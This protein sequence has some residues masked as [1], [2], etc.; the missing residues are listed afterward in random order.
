VELIAEAQ[1]E[2]PI[3]INGKLRDVVSVP[4]G[5]SEV[6]VEQIVLAR[7]KVRAQL[8][9]NEIVRIVQVPGRLVNIVTR[10]RKVS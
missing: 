2:V 8:E 6:E 1:L 4:A 9:G 10:P 5:L 7:D 3:Q